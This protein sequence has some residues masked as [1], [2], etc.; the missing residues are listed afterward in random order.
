VALEARL[1]FKSTG[2]TGRV[3]GFYLQPR[4]AFESV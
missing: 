2:T 3:F 1:R 4:L